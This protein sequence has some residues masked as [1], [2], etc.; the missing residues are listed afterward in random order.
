MAKIKTGICEVHL[1]NYD[2]NKK[3]KVTWRGECTLWICSKCDD[4]VLI[5]MASINKKNTILKTKK[6]WKPFPH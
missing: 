5:A 4:P 1:Y 3:R 2:D 6:T